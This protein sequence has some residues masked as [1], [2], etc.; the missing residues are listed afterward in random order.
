MFH[1]QEV[2]DSVGDP[3]VVFP[4]GGHVLDEDPQG[5][6]SNCEHLSALGQINLPGTTERGRG[7]R[8]QG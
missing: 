7:I 1:V 3:G 5:L 4:A 6:R 2:G 8:G